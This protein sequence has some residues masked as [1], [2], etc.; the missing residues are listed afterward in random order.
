[1]NAK[2]K[3][4]SDGPAKDSAAVLIVKMTLGGTKSKRTLA[5]PAH[6]NAKELL[7]VALDAFGF[8]NSHLSAFRSEVLGSSTSIDPMG[9]E[10]E[11]F[12]LQEE[13][14]SVWQAPLARIFPV[15]GTRA[16][17]EYD[18]GDGWEISLRRMADKK[19]APEPFTCLKSEGVDAIDDC[20]GP[21]GLLSIARIAGIWLE[22][23]TRSV[24]ND[25][26]Y[27]NFKWMLC[28]DE[29]P[30]SR[31][32]EIEAFVAGPSCEEITDRIS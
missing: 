9:G 6:I 25:D 17:I 18:F 31:R 3:T 7:Y 12:G 20:G 16:K 29:E 28:G 30:E 26:E 10:Q 13:D 5:L 4:D 2:S 32:K 14:S 22:K 23:G 19:T 8:D 1:M 24:R 11:S 27:E 15:V 21:W